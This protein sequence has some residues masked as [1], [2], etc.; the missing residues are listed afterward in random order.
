[1]AKKCPRNID[2]NWQPMQRGSKREQCRNCETVYPCR[3]ACDHLD[4]RVDRGDP[5]PEGVVY[6]KKEVVSP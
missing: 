3:H 1:M 5:M 6:I 2:H 4:C